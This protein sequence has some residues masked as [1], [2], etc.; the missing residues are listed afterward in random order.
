MS[1][2]DRHIRVV[3]N[4]LA[5]GRLVEGLAWTL[6][7][8]AGV[9]LIGVLGVRLFSLEVEG[10]RVWLGVGLA[11]A[12]ALAVGYAIWRRPGAHEAAVAIDRTLGLKE[13][14]STALYARGRE[15]EFARAAVADAEESAKAVSLRRRFPLRFPRIGYAAAGVAI[16]ALLAAKFVK[17]MDLLGHEQQRLAL[18]QEQKRT[19]ESKKAIGEA[20]ARI[21]SMPAEVTNDPKVKEA[22]RELEEMLKSPPKDPVQA[23]MAAQKAL[24]DV[25]ESL[26]RTIDQSQNYA[27]A[28]QDRKQFSQMPATGEQGPVAQAQRDMANGDFQSAI[29]HLRQAVNDFEKMSDQER[30]AAARQMKELA[31]Q[32]QKMANNPE[33]RRQMEEKLQE[34]GATPQQAQQMAQLMQQAAAGD[35]QAQRQ[36]AQM[37]QQLMRQMNNGQG[38]TPQQQQQ[39]Q[40]TMTQLQAQANSQQQAQQLAQNAQQ[41][42]DA[43]NQ[44]KGQQNQPDNTQM[45]QSQQAMQQQLQQMR[46]AQNQANQ[47]AQA[48]KSTSGGN[49]ANGPG[50]QPN[51]GA[52][53]DGPEALP[54]GHAGSGEGR[55]AKNEGQPG[56]YKTDPAAPPP[57]QKD[58]KVL[59]ST[60]VQANSIK[61]ES[62]EQLRDVAEA[63]Q[64]EQMD[65]VDQQRISRQSQETVKNYFG[66]MREDAK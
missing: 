5:L 55:H 24:Q 15:D 3:R 1:R 43:M 32:L 65:E 20:M 48:Q 26:K 50:Q 29:D 62:K 46:N 2:I 38:P 7:G 6:L 14:F 34:M 54:G 60:Y 40:Q 10:A 56:N 42:A 30:E 47:L 4:K 51:P 19:E 66:Q 53:A 35:Q 63:A 21:D 52:M 12:V 16:L 57:D 28:Q 8:L 64:H 44:P 45:A 49:Q 61:G 27:N 36:L 13:K 33:T 37:Q 31:D 17:P 22:R 25:K 11:A 39:F 58:G 41:M 23:R 18:A 9:V 59:A